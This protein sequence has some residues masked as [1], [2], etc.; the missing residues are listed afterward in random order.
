MRLRALVDPPPFAVGSL[1]AA[2]PDRAPP[3]RAGPEPIAMAPSVA[4]AALM[5]TGGPNG[6]GS[7][8]TDGCA[9]RVYC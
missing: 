9:P 8:T 7:V 6:V 3:A 2:A 4:P 1:A 5:S